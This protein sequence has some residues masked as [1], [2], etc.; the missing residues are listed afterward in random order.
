MV[1][2][3]H[4]IHVACSFRNWKLR[5]QSYISILLCSSPQSRACSRSVAFVWSWPFDEDS[6]SN[7]RVT[8][9]RTGAERIPCS[10]YTHLLCPVR[11][12]ELLLPIVA[13][14]STSKASCA[15]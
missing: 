10:S 15:A 11:P 7:G 4:E 13:L 1:D 6:R 12:S 2:V 9:A 14:L 3:R 5:R 8:R